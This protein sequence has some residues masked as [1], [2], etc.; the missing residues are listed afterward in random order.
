MTVLGTLAHGWTSVSR[1]WTLQAWLI[2]AFWAWRGFGAFFG[3]PR[4]P[5]LLQPEWDKAPHTG[6]ELTVIVPALNEAANVGA[7]L[8]SLLAQDYAALRIIAVDDRSTD[9]TGAIMDALAEAHP[10]R[11]RVIHIAE[12]PSGWLGKTHAMALAAESAASEYLLFTDADVKYLPDALRRSMA[13]AV[14]SRADHLVT[15]PTLEVRGWD[16]AALL[17]V[18]QL[19]GLWAARPWKVE[20]PKAKRDAVGI[21]AFN[22][23]RRAAYEQ[24]GGFKALRMEIVEDV[25]MARRVRKAKLRQRLAFGRGLVTVHWA[26]GAFGLVRVLTKNMFSAFGFRIP[27]LL[28]VCAMLVVFFIAPFFDLLAGWWMKDLLLP[29]AVACLSIVA[30]YRATE[31]FSGISSWFV[32]LTPFA[33]MLMI[34]A[35]LLSMVTTLRQGGVV[36][37][38]TFYSLKELRKNV[39]PLW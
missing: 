34:Y 36:W 11:L 28:F 32:L 27:L 13:Y 1:W 23:M 30:A 21:G 26:S 14:V 20:D 22:L 39:A 18:F 10:E 25:G 7:C 9:G 24:L 4:V 33:A 38:G 12:L 8:T 31:R 37:R 35:L 17:G 5:D 16:E 2:A 19:C 3:I 29:A 6:P 15:A